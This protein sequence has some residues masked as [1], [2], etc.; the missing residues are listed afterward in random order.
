MGMPV[1]KRKMLYHSNKK[2]KGENTKK[3]NF[4]T[5]WIWR[6]N[7]I[8]GWKKVNFPRRLLNFPHISGIQFLMYFFITFPYKY[9]N[10]PEKNFPCRLIIPPHHWV[11]SIF[12]SKK[13]FY[14]S[15]V[16]IKSRL[17]VELINVTQL[18]CIVTPPLWSLYSKPFLFAYILVY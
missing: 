7:W 3:R 1:R 8:Q 11:Y 17:L 18:C 14:F 4:L 12:F 5:H 6:P 16:L 15:I 9:L 10:F 2:R 13:H